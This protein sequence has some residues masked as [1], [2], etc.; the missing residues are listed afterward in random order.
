MPEPTKMY[1]NDLLS[2]H[3]GHKLEV[4]EYLCGVCGTTSDFMLRC[5]QDE[6]DDTCHN[7]PAGIAR[8]LI[9]PECKCSITD[10]KNLKKLRDNLTQS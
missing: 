4:V 2:N 5:F 10:P 7:D 9:L 8:E 3:I 6:I 1:F